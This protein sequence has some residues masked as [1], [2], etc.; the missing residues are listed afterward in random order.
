MPTDSG[1][2]D[3]PSCSVNL[4]KAY[5]VLSGP[6]SLLQAISLCMKLWIEGIMLL[7]QGQAVCVRWGVGET[8]AESPTRPRKVDFCLTR[9]NKF[10]EEIHTYWQ[11]E[12]LFFVNECLS[13]A[14]FFLAE[15]FFFFV[16]GCSSYGFQSQG[17]CRWCWFSRLPLANHFAHAH[18]WSA[19]GPFLVVHTSLNQDGFQSKGFWE[20]CRIIR[21]WC[22]LPPFGPSW[23]L[24][25][26]F[27]GSL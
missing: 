13:R 8:G 7:G 11:N 12:R 16:N 26:G 3:C 18:I 10:S 20:V 24:P 21:G 17:L 1:F 4:Q 9:R 27:G 5:E 6:A 15:H 23:I 2:T 25:V 14:F 19:S 22:L